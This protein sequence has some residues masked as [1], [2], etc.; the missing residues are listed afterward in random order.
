MKL[1]SIWSDFIGT[2]SR[3][4][5]GFRVFLG[6]SCGLPF[7]LRLTVLDLWLKESGV[8]NTVIGLFTLLHWPFAL[9]F[10]WAP[11]IERMDFPLLSRLFGR[12][13]GWAM[14]SQLL[15]FLGLTG[16]AVS[17]PRSS[18]CS[19]MVF[20]SIVAFADGCQDMAIYPYQLDGAKM[21]MFGPI[22]GVF[23][24]GYRLG[25]FFAKSGTLYLAHYLGWNMAYAM[26]AFS[27][28]LCTFFILCAKEPQNPQTEQGKRIEKM[29]KSYEKHPSSRFEFVRLI[30]ATIFECLV[31]PFRIFMQRRGW[32]SLIAIIV[33]F[34]T[35]DMV[36][37]KMVKPFFVDMG[38]SMLE[39][40][41]VVQVFGTIATMFGGVLGGF[42]I[43]RAGILK[44][45]FYTGLFHAISCFSYVILS[46]TGHNLTALYVTVFL[47]SV[48][49]GAVATA[50]IA[51]LYTLCNKNR[52]AA[53]QYALLWAFY[54][55][56]GMVCRTLSGIVADGLG[57]TRFFIF[58][59]ATFVPSLIILYFL[60]TRKRSTGAKNRALFFR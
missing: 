11:F 17:D 13:C 20:A 19:L 10:L 41:N 39:I 21:K 58:V 55:L 36:T 7:L 47:E 1:A 15:L 22:A 42:F 46:K 31:C 43:K 25:M 12:R 14:A 5:A 29:V 38:F 26:M 49:G 35:G 37:Q 18:M 24:F 23:V 16:M 51:F 44:A 34:R 28:F 33:L 54:D 27:I 6:F 8:S 53:T 32:K 3:T 59:P 40:A 4:G 50:F 52:Y 30:R 45:M 60:V 2:Y 56:S 9:K 57:W 48:T